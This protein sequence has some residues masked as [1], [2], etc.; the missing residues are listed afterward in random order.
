MSKRKGGRIHSERKIK[1]D[2]MKTANYKPNLLTTTEP[3]RPNQ[4]TV[5]CKQK[6]RKFSLGEVRQGIADRCDTIFMHSHVRGFSS[7]TWMIKENFRGRCQPR[8]SGLSE[9]TCS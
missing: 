8:L 5:L 4:A 9:L 3:F 7:P 2:R 6:T 1:Y